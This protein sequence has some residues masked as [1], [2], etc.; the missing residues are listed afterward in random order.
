MLQA[1]WLEEN[2]SDKI[3]AIN[4]AKWWFDKLRN[5]YKN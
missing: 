5:W 1:E 4:I 3:I 2:I